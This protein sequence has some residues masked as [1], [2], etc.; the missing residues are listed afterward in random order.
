MNGD[1]RDESHVEMRPASTSTAPPTEE[2]AVEELAET[3]MSD[4]DVLAAERDDY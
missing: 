1:G 2:G 3:V 4:L